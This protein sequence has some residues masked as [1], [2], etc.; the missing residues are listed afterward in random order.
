M[1][2][3]LSLLACAEP[4]DFQDTWGE[5]DVL[6]QIAL[7]LEEPIPCSGPG[8]PVC[9]DDN[10]MTLDKC[11]QN[12]CVSKPSPGYCSP[13]LYGCNDNNPCTENICNAETLTCSYPPLA[14]CCLKDADCQIGGPL[15]GHP[16]SQGICNKQTHM[17]EFQVLDGCCTSD[18]DCVYGTDCTVDLCISNQCKYKTKPG[19]CLSSNGCIDDN[20]CTVDLCDAASN[21]CVHETDLSNPLCCQ[22]SLDCDDGTPLT[23]DLCINHFCV[24]NDLPG[25]C[26][27]LPGVP[28]SPCEDGNPCTC[29]L[30]FLGLC[31]PVPASLAPP[32]CNIPKNCCLQ[33]SDCTQPP[34]PYAAGSCNNGLCEYSPAPGGVP[35]P[36]LEPF[37]ACAPIEESGWLWTQPDPA[38]SAAFECTD[39]GPSGPDNHYRLYSVNSPFE[40][41]LSTPPLLPDLASHVT[42]QLDYVIAGSHGTAG[43]YLLLDSSTQ[44]SGGQDKTV[45]LWERQAAPKAWSSR[46]SIEIPSEELCDGM[47]IAFG[48]T[49]TALQTIEQFD[50]DSLRICPGRS[51]QFTAVPNNLTIS[52]GAAQEWP[53][54]GADPDGQP[55]AFWLVSGPDFVNVSPLSSSTASLFVAPAPGESSGAYPARLAVSDGCLAQFHTFSISIP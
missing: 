47:R 53:I 39:Q 14:D 42:I 34:V 13:G 33:D 7:A 20:I 8:D 46:L 21:T 22:T 31:R 11:I 18:I 27:G 5:Q 36:L 45:S 26:P 23:E 54:A 10:P 1:L 44:C 12:K 37:A 3:V 15:D 24:H 2:L 19:C 6:A 25:S 9:D 51:P 17:C 49:G 30:C 40:A 28:Y 52:P 29:D 35:L 48:I 16:C 50:I 43:L 41:R 32:S 38:G 55:L 4:C